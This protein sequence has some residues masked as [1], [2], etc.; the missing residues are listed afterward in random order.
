MDFSYGKADQKGDYGVNHTTFVILVD[1]KAEQVALFT[2][3]LDAKR[4]SA[5]YLDILKY[6]GE[7]W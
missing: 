5:D 2:P 7:T 4:M 1:R 3:P 6:Y